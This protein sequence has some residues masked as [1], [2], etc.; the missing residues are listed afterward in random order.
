MGFLGNL[1]KNSASEKAGNVVSGNA[2]RSCMP[3]NARR[4][5]PKTQE[6]ILVSLDKLDC[7]NKMVVDLRKNAVSLDKTI[8]NLEKAKG[9]NLQG[10]QAKVAFIL[11]YSGSMS[12]VYK[13]GKMQQILNRFLPLAR[14]VDDNGEA[15]VWLFDKGCRRITPMNLD[16][17]SDYVE[18]NIIKAGYQ[19]GGWTNYAPALKDMLDKYY[20][21]DAATSDIPVFVVFVTDGNNDDKDETNQVMRESADL[22]DFVQYFGIG[23]RQFPYLEKLDDLDGRSC[24]NTGFIKVD[25]ILN[26]P[27]DE[28]FEK[29]LDQYPD[30]LRAKGVAV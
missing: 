24:D 26:M 23:K 4:T 22:N 6:S 16:N 18:K 11:D 3:I 15:D 5:T 8:L 14:R 17:F 12:D 27:E 20:I 13:S 9:V 10:M 28:M 30:W 29:M 7:S 21:E 25:D 1:R 19:M 2:K